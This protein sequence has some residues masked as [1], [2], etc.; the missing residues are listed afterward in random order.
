MVIGEPLPFV[1]AYIEELDHALRTL[2][3]HA[4]LSPYRR[5]W[6]GFC[7]LA[8]IVTN[9]V[10]WK[11]FDRA[12][13]GRW[14]HARLSWLFRQAKRFWRYL[15]RASVMVL[16]AR[17]H[18]TEGIAVFD[19]S[20]NPRS[21]STTRIYKTYKLHHKPSGGTVNGQSVVVLVLV[22]P[23]ITLPVGFE[24]YM[25]DPAVTAWKKQD[26]ALRKRGVPAKDRPKK[27]VRN[28]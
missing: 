27:P 14:P 20:D 24:F 16:L 18:I 22:T 7:V 25:P 9:S 23:R 10:C 13:L 4:G 11:R 17:Y 21:K 26:Q 6:L 28:P 15:L 2:D 12:S 3:A 19:D 5:A 8:I 1:N